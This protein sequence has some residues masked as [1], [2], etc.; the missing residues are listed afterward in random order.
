MK[1]KTLGTVPVTI[2]WYYIAF[3]VCAV[4]SVQVLRVRIRIILEI[5]I[6][7]RI[8]INRLKIEPHEGP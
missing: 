5:Q 1:S 7:I 3:M 2:S 8:R 4:Q 6:R